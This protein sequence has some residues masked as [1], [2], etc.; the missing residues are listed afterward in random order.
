MRKTQAF[1]SLPCAIGIALKYGEVSAVTA[2]HYKE[3]EVAKLAEKVTIETDEQAE[4]FYNTVIVRAKDGSKY[5]ISGDKFPN[6]THDQVKNNLMGAA[7]KFASESRVK[8]L[9]QAVDNIEK[10]SIGDLSELLF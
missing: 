10:I 9:I 5:T 2:N 1:K 7:I 8:D 3:P 6:L 4:G